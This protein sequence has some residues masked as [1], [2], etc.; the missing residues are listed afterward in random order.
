MKF[1]YVIDIVESFGIYV[2]DRIKT[3]SFPG[4][5]ADK[6]KQIGMHQLGN[7]NIPDSAQTICRN[8]LLKIGAIR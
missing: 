4:M 3:L 2:F 5:S 6:V 8:W 7:Y 1:A